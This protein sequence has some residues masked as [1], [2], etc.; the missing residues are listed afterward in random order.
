MPVVL[1]VQMGRHFFVDPPNCYATFTYE[2]K[3]FRTE[4]HHGATNPKWPKHKCEL[5]YEGKPIEIEFAVMQRK[6]REEQVR[7]ASVTIKWENLVPG[8]RKVDDYD[9]IAEADGVRDTAAIRVAATLIPEGITGSPQEQR[10]NGPR[11]KALF[12]GICYAGTS[13]FL[14]MCHEDAWKMKDFFCEH[15]GFIDAPETIKVLMDAENTPESGRTSKRE[16]SGW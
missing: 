7:I 9:V 16:S 3:E 6:S 10:E 11:R 12:V 14:E 5:G 4:T 2:G 13:S 15:Y 8:L 1:E